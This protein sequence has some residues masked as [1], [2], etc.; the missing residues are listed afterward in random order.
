VVSRDVYFVETQ[1]DIE[2]PAPL[3]EA[4]SVTHWH[5]YHDDV[6]DF[7]MECDL[8]RREQNSP[9]PESGEPDPAS[10]EKGGDERRT[11]LEESEAEVNMPNLWSEPTAEGQVEPQVE[12][13]QRESDEAIAS[14][15]ESATGRIESREGSDIPVHP[16]HRT[17]SSGPVGNWSRTLGRVWDNIVSNAI[18]EAPV[19]DEDSEGEIGDENERAMM[20]RDGPRNIRVALKE[21]RWREAIQKE[22]DQMMDVNAWDLVSLPPGR[23]AVPFIWV[24]KLKVDED[25]KAEEAKARLVV[26][27]GQQVAGQDYTSMFVPTLWCCGRFAVILCVSDGGRVSEDEA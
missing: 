6:S 20:T 9:D 24:L 16:E 19:G 14:S 13:G 15:G 17:R 1:F 8:R 7:D 21:P 23:H 18:G 27:G 10:S 5:R 25:S 11:A 22:Y 3:A 12:A 2:N 26:H 4:V